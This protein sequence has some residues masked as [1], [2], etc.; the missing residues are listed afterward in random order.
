MMGHKI[1][2]IEKIWKIIPKLSQLPQLFGALVGQIKI[3]LLLSELSLSRVAMVREK[4][5]ENEIFSR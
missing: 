3:R 5:L 2:F 1:C 4:Y